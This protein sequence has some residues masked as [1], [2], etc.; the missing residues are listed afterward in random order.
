MQSKKSIVA[1][2]ANIII[3]YLLKDNEEFYS[4]ADKF[5]EEVFSGKKAAYI[6]QSVLAELIYVFTKFYKI[7][8]KQV[9]ETLEELLS[10]RNIKIQDKDITLNALYIFKTNNID[11]VDCLLCAYSEEMEIFSFDKKLNKCTKEVKTSYK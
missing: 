2:D 9:V 5:F 11:F 6:L 3:R 1:I 4:L 7:N 10:S 8:K